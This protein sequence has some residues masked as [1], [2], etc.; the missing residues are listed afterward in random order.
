MLVCN[1]GPTKY[2]WPR[3]PQSHNPALPI[4]NFLWD[5]A[6]VSNGFRDIRRRLTQAVNIDFGFRTH[7]LATIH[8]EHTTTD[9]T[10]YSISETVNTVG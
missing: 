6:S 3:A 8:S 4:C 7:R 2:L 5:Q 10:L 1:G 9:A